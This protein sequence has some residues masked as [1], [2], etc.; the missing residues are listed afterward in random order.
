M[1]KIFEFLRRVAVSNENNSKKIR[2]ESLAGIRNQEMEFAS[3]VNC[4]FSV[5]LRSKTNWDTGFLKN[6]LA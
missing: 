1:A 3:L 6:N 2:R 4:V 5:P